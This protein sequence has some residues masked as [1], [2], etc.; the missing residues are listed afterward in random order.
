MASRHRQVQLL[1]A[2]AI[3]VVF[4]PALASATDYVVGDKA[5]WTLNYTVGWPEGKTFKVNDNLGTEI[6]LQFCSHKN[7]VVI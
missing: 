7:R 1:A 3:A 5:G 6:E 2:A 4:L